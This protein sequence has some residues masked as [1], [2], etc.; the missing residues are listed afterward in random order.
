MAQLSGDGSEGPQQ[1]Q[2]PNPPQRTRK[3]HTSD[4]VITALKSLSNR[5]RVSMNKAIG[6][7]NAMRNL[8]RARNVDKPSATFVDSDNESTITVSDEG[9][10][11]SPTTSVM[12]A[13]QKSSPA[14]ALGLTRALMSNKRTRDDDLATA[15]KGK[16]LREE[17][18]LPEGLAAP[19]VYN[20]LLR[21]LYNHDKYL[22][23]SLF[24]T[25]N[26]EYINSNASALPMIKLNKL[27]EAS[28]L[29]KPGLF[30]DAETF[31]RT[32]LREEDLNRGQWGEAAKNHNKFIAFMTGVGSPAHIRWDQHFA[33]F[34]SAPDAEQNYAA[35]LEADIASR[36]R[37]ITTPF[38]YNPAVYR[39]DLDKAVRLLEIKQT[40]E[41]TLGTISHPTS[42]A[43]RLPL[44]HRDHRGA[45]GSGAKVGS[46]GGGA[47]GAAPFQ[48]G[49]G[50]DATTAVCLVCARRGHWCKDCTYT[51]LSNG[52]PTYCVAQGEQDI[53]TVRSGETLCRIWNSKGAQAKCKHHAAARIHACSFCGS[54]NHHAFAWSC[55]QK[56]PAA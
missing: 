36:K 39:R 3:T 27:D 4:A 1:Q 46:G 12:K 28:V 25:A 56:P 53:N 9:M 43:P 18:D 23:L 51:T 17:I 15:P 7:R 54:K 30:F 40:V 19:I 45:E 41:A 42:D 55:V 6:S 13:I 38:V 10:E 35:H 26:L 32:H 52:S 29:S 48:R 50:G 31:Q 5:D 8:G 21:E 16:K 2:N 22:P 20:V 24:T 47:Q 33:Y 37:Y 34:E 49:N 44:S 14:T 11:D